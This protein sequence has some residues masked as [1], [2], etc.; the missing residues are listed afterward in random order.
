[1]GSL[2]GV[3]D[4]HPAPFRVRRVRQDLVGRAGVGRS[5]SVG[6]TRPAAP[7][8]G[9]VDAE[10]AGAVQPGAGLARVVLGDDGRERLTGRDPAVRGSLVYCC[11]AGICWAWLTRR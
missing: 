8:T 7:A 10:G 6:R 3:D 9:D 1:V 5:I 11:M 4:G 2:A